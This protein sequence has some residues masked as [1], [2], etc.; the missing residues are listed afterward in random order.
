MA[1]DASVSSLSSRSVN[2]FMVEPPSPGSATTY[3]AEVLLVSGERLLYMSDSFAA[4]MDGLT[5]AEV[6]V[7]EPMLCAA[8]GA[9]NSAQYHH[10]WQPGDVI[11]Y[12]N[13][14][15][16]HYAVADYFPRTRRVLHASR[17]GARAFVATE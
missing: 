3:V 5:P 14:A 8:A 4:G 16:Q 17:E 12:D 2:R 7:L 1:E 11:L 9:N 13:L 6:G 10:H 15:L